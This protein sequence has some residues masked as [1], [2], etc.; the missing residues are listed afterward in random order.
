MATYR[1]N[2]RKN[3]GGDER[4]NSLGLDSSRLHRLLDILDQN[5]GNANLKRVHVRWPF[6]H[7]S[8]L[9]RLVEGFGSRRE[10][11]VAARNLSNSG[12]SV[13]HNSYVHPG[14]D[15]EIRL[16]TSNGELNETMLVQGKVRRCQHVQGVVHEVGVEFDEAI[17][18][19]HFLSLNAMPAYYSLETIDLTKLE[20]TILHVED[21]ALDR[22]LFAHYLADTRV[23]IKAAENIED[24]K[25]KARETFDLIVLDL[26][27]PDG[28]AIEFVSWLRDNGI[29]TPVIVMT[30]ITGFDAQRELGTAEINGYLTKPIDPATLQRAVT[31]YL[32]MA[33]ERS[34]ESDDSLK[35]LAGD[36]IAELGRVVEELRECVAN[37]DAMG[38]YSIVLRLQGT[39][40]SLGFTQL[41]NV[42][43]RAAS[44]LASTMS[45]EESQRQLDA[46]LDACER[47]KHRRAG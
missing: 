29:L 28:N 21:S 3:D 4:R 20:G 1:A 12:L 24:A 40:P 45:C 25:Q 26:G 44:T 6:R 8:V 11:K 36:F 46:L 32:R 15:C 37:S 39:A 35:A 38:A 34:T 14:Q 10:F 30:A 7:D 9:F 27:L 23:I 42:C 5:R 41:A 13:L 16:P 31:E 22:R 33:D 47:L 2:F 43:D 19:R 17:D 18:A